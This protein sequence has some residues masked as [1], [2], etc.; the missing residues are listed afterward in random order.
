M[1][2]ER[3][4]INTDTQIISHYG[5]PSWCP[6]YKC[7]A[8]E[9]SYFNPSRTQSLLA[10]WS[11]GQDSSIGNRRLGPSRKP[12]TCDN[13]CSGDF[14]RSVWLF[15][16]LSYLVKFLLFVREQNVGERAWFSGVVQKLSCFNISVVRGPSS[17]F[18]WSLVNCH[19]RAWVSRV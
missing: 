2:S 7:V 8:C 4:L 3:P 10:F 6:R 18:K 11:P 17:T 9:N 1:F 16:D 19:G 13:T 15:C 12:L 5:M 14:W